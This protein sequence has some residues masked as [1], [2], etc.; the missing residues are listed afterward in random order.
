MVV[1]QCSLDYV[2]FVDGRKVQDKSL[3]FFSFAEKRWFDREEGKREKRIGG[4]SCGWFLDVIMTTKDCVFF[5][6]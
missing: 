4:K 3:C 5:L 2:H 6:P 1:A